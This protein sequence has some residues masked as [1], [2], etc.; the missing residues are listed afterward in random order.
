MTWLTLR[1]RSLATRLNRPVDNRARL[2]SGYSLLFFKFRVLRAKSWDSCSV[3]QPYERIHN[4]S[5]ENTKIPLEGF[6]PLPL[7]DRIKRFRKARGWSQTQLAQAIGVTQS[8]VSLWERG[9]SRPTP[10]SFV[11]FAKHADDTDRAIWVGEAGLA[12]FVVDDEM[13]GMRDIPVLKDAAAAGTPRAV[14]PDSSAFT[15]ALPR[16]WFQKSG[17]LF[18]IR[19]TGD[20]MSPIIS[21]GALLVID[22]ADRDAATL[23]DE[24]VVASDS[25]GGITIKWLRRDAGVYFLVPQNTS[26]RHPIRLLREGDGWQVVAK[27]VKII[28]DPPA[29]RRK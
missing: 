1:F 9:D 4:L 23:V 13:S 18:G 24:M 7:K 5:M 16:N 6:V 22:V 3:S 29:P 15:L 19:S 17:R 28:S 14:D 26:P 2:I 10:T 27:V 20:S 12:Q 25:E 21:E 8:L 11:K